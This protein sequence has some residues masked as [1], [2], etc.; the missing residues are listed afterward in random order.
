M[1]S[2]ADFKVIFG[3]DFTALTDTVTGHS[4]AHPFS[5]VSRYSFPLTLAFRLPVYVM[6][7]PSVR[8]QAGT[9]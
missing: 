7:L 5:F 8:I 3:T 6:L 2:V 9:E 1:L 4:S